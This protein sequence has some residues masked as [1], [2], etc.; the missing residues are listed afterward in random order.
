[1]A[2]IASIKRDIASMKR[3]IASMKRDIASMK[4]GIESMKEDMKQEIR[5]INK[6]LYWWK[7]RVARVEEAVEKAKVGIEECSTRVDNYFNK[8]NDDNGV[9]AV[10]DASGVTGTDDN[11]VAS[12]DGGGKYDDVSTKVADMNLMD[13]A[14][15]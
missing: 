15:N 1:M 3:D 7:P 10:G 9:S 13:D 4:E 12:V 8:A 5:F 11:T 14:D 6:D 2:D